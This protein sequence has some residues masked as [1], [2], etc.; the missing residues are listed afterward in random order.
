MVDVLFDKLIDN[1]T[2]SMVWR[3]IELLQNE[4]TE[5]T[6]AEEQMEESGLLVCQELFDER[7]NCTEDQSTLVSLAE[8]GE[9]VKKRR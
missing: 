8:V 9:A 1:E 2:T 5:Q 4:N 7:E 3:L 6:N